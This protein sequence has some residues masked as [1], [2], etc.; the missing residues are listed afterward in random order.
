MTRLELV[1]EKPGDSPYST[2]EPL[3]RRLPPGRHGIPANLV[4]EHQRR[5]LRRAIA[6]TAAP[7]LELQAVSC[8]AAA[9]RKGASMNS[10]SSGSRS[11]AFS[12]S[13]RRIC[14]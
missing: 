3:P 8:S 7:E 6:V 13:W 4:V 12:V 1:T 10:D 11:S 9:L 5:R 2:A 14:W